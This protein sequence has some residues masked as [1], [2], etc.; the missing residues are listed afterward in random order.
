MDCT[1]KTNKCNMP[2]FNTVGITSNNPAFYS[3]FTFFRREET[4]DYLWALSKFK[5]LQEKKSYP[6]VN[7]SDRELT[8]MNALQIICG[9]QK[10]YH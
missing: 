5:D 2:L 7:V 3:C 8:L 4:T 10:K 6:M 1:Y 9:T